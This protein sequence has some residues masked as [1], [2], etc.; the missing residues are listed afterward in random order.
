MSV[1]PLANKY[2][3]INPYN[4]TANNPLYYI[5]SNGEDLKNA[6]LHTIGAYAYV[7]EVMGGVGLIFEGG[8]PG[9]I[10]G[11][12][13]L[14]HGGLSAAI[15]IG[16]IG[17]ELYHEYSGERIYQYITQGINE[18]IASLTTDNKFKINT[19]AITDIL[20]N[21]F[22][23]GSKTKFIHLILTGKSTKIEKM[24]KLGEEILIKWK[25][26]EDITNE[27]NEFQKMIEAFEEE[28]DE[29][30]EEENEVEK[31]ERNFNR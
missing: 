5:D 3:F 8:V 12:A 11:S 27:I 30:Y 18:A 10:I 15:E 16:N 25:T 29:N 26:G 17:N 23:A 6:I 21:V 9:M 1:D 31:E 4:Y 19:W 2:P 28:S 24:V 14:I 7:Q 13:Q 20:L 22:S